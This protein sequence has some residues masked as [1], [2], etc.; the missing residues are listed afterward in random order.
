MN[1]STRAKALIGAVAIGGSAVAMGGAFTAGGIGGTAHSTPAFI[2]GSVD[3]SITGATM[4]AIV[5]D[6]DEAANK[7][8]SVELTFTG[9]AADGKTPV[10]TFTGATVNGTYTCAAIDAVNHKS[11][12]TAT[13]KADSNVSSLDINI[14]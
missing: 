2:G 11:A 4:S 1:T 7:I 5:Y 13:T 10:I 6:V 14:V 9:T 3:Q 8:T 12:C